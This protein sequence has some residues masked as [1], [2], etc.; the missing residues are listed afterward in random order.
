MTDKPKIFVSHIHEEGP[1]A[2]VIKTEI[3]DAFGERVA[4]FVS[5][6]PGDNPGGGNWLERIAGELRDEQTCMLIALVSPTSISEP[7]ISLEL[8][9]AWILNRAV[10][11]LC[12]SGQEIG[13][14]PRPLGDFVGADVTNQ[15]N[16][17]A[18][19][20]GAAEMATSYKVPKGWSREN[21]LMAMRQASGS[22][23]A[24]ITRAPTPSARKVQLA[25]IEPFPSEVTLPPEQIQ[26]MQE[27]ARA[28]NAGREDLNPAAICF[29]CKI[30]PAILKYHAKE[31]VK[32]KFTHDSYYAGE[33][34]Y[35]LTADGA[36]WL[37]QNGQMP[38]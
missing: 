21:F 36:G 34:H 37:I 4:V 19:L 17:A 33:V 2:A 11:P 8:G 13:K 3:E 24:K 18:I 1:L 28:H 16:A 22:H 6:N 5:S 10:F 14:L 15:D 38:A 25:G 9:A 23:T 30:A 7:W 32:R 29:A 31:L 20:I 26:I 35:S 12:H 27:L